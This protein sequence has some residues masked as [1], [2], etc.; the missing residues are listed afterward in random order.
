M[1]NKKLFYHVANDSVEN[2]KQDMA[3]QNVIGFVHSGKSTDFGYLVSGGKQYGISND[4]LDKKINSAV[5]NVKLQVDA[6]NS[7]FT[8]ADG[9]QYSLTIDP[10]TNK[11]A[12]SLYQPVSFDFAIDANE[13]SNLF[14]KRISSNI[15]QYVG[16]SYSITTGVEYVGSTK[17]TA[18]VGATDGTYQELVAYYYVN[19]VLH[20]TSRPFTGLDSYTFANMEINV[21]AATK[22]SGTV[23]WGHKVSITSNA[24]PAVN[25]KVEL[26]ET[27]N[28]E[29]NPYTKTISVPKI[30]AT[31]TITPQVPVID[32][33]IEGSPVVIANLTKGNETVNKSHTLKKNTQGLIAVPTCINK[34]LTLLEMGQPSTCKKL[35]SNAEKTFTINGQICK[36]YFDI[37]HYG[38]TQ[39]TLAGDV[40]VTVKL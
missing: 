23:A 21:P 14:W 25:Y 8:T 1:S 13:N 19:D 30:T 16:S 11:I 18:S 2:F 27:P 12:F 9:K 28:S 7:S 24:V 37:Y 3:T 29:N 10:S 40:T 5:N 36:T 34:T 20:K 26:W 31:S 35:Q 6:N 32:C 39:E 4:Q 17:P 33:S 15:T 38:N 22:S